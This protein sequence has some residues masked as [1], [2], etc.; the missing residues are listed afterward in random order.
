[1]PHDAGTADKA[2]SQRTPH[3]PSRIRLSAFSNTV[4]L[5]GFLVLAVGGVVFWLE[6]TALLGYIDGQYL[7]TL[8]RN[9]ADFAPRLPF[10]SPNPLEGLGDLWF[11]VNTRWLPELAIPG[12]FSDVGVQRTVA[13]CIASLE[14]FV[15][16]AILARWLRWPTWQAI[17][18]GWAAIIFIEPFSFPSLNY[19]SP[20]APEFGSVIAVPLLIFLLWAGIGTGRAISDLLRGG[21]ILLLLWM[22]FLAV[23]LFTT[24]SY[25]FLLINACVLLIGTWS[26]RKEFLRKTIWS[27][28][29]L[30]LVVATGLPAA[31]IGI[32]T[33]TAFQFFPDV[34]ARP[35][36]P[37]TDCS[38]LF[39]GNLASKIAMFGYAGMLGYAFF[40]W[41]RMRL[42][43]IAQA[44]A[45]TGL[46]IA[47]LA[48]HW[49]GYTA[50]IPLYFEYVLWPLY[51][52]FAV[53]VIAQVLRMLAP[54]GNLKLPV[55]LRLGAWIILP[56]A[57]V[58]IIHGSRW[59]RPE[60]PTR[61]NVFPPEQSVITKELER[62]I[63]LA[64]GSPFRGR[65]ATLTG[66]VAP[67]GF[68]WI[69]MFTQDLAM[70]RL[71]GNE[72]RSI[73][74]WYYNIPT[75]MEFSHTVSPLLFAATTRYLAIPEDPPFRTLLHMRRSNLNIL[76]LL[77]VSYIVSDA[78]QAVPGTSDIATLPMPKGLPAP[79]LEAVPDPNL[80]VSPT[81][82]IPIESADDA[83][84]QLGRPDFNFEQQVILS[85]PAP[86]NLVPA[87]DIRVTIVR[88][89]IRVTARGSGK[90][91][92]VVPFQYS[93]CLSAVSNIGGDVQ[94]SRAD[95]LLTAVTF[96]NDLD[97]TIT[98]RNPLFAGA[99]CWLQN[100]ADDRQLLRPSS[101]LPSG[102][103]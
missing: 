92:V 101:P 81:E 3:Y 94:L 51:P 38:L 17:A 90:S 37:L 22:H 71:I 79:R 35:D 61:P 27:G 24:L 5:Q 21:I 82:A 31:A 45:V 40:G 74:F 84:G 32:T 77:G 80:G 6:R 19:L 93:H 65:V 83:V 86:G 98:Y 52:L 14:I 43:A 33:D 54:A 53:A 103:P 50:S 44:I 68:S 9:Q 73:G 25:P 59:L 42:F 95:I 89:G 29:L 91:L 100:R 46:I 11:F 62:R 12:L 85:G 34:L 10:F 20:D 70:I 66:Q 36:R 39:Q 26:R 47:S 78:P 64:V 60:P 2:E 8:I 67:P 7:L 87:H 55:A 15:A 48:Y 99:Y 75:L 4:S 23:S 41:D 1:M 56:C 102:H 13:H 69:E 96:E 18:A 49:F 76:R 88:G 97:V 30:A 28:V 58:A 16:I 72:H 57:A 63:G